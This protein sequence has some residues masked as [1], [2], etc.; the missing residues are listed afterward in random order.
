MQTHTKYLLASTVL[1]S[2]LIFC[3]GNVAAQDTTSSSSAVLEEIQV[4][5][6]RVSES[7]QT[8]PVSVT[9]IGASMLEDGDFT[10]LGDIQKM[11]PNLTLHVGDASNAV[12]YIR[13]VGQVDSLAFAD[14]GVG[15]YMDDVYLGRAQGA[16]LDVL[17][18]ERI[19][20]LRGPQGTLYGRNTIG[21]AVK[22]V[23]KKPGDTL[24][25]DA[26]ITVGSYD[27]L[28]VKAS[29]GGPIV[30]DKL[31]GKIS[32]AY[33][34]RDGFATNE[35]NGKDDSDK[36][37]WA[38]KAGLYF[39]PTED[40]SIDFTL[41][42]SESH[43][44]TSRTPARMTSVFG[45]AEPNDDP[46]VI[47][48]DFNDLNKLDVYGGAAT[49]AYDATDSLTL[50]SITS[51]REMTYDTHLDL[52]AT[53]FAFFGI[54]VH[55]E[56]NQFSQ[57]LQLSYTS[58]ALDVIG[59][60]YYFKEHDNT[61]AG[62]FGPVIAFVSGSVN[63]QH[64]KS[65]AGYLNT[66]Y[67]MND[68]LSLTAGIRYTKE[69]KDFDRIQ[70]FFSADTLLPVPI[71]QG[72]RVTDLTVD[73]TWSS[74]SPKVGFDYQINDDLMAYVSASRGFKSG[75]F[76][77][78]SNSADEAIPFDPETMWSYETGL[79]STL[80]D[81]RM[82]LNIAGFMNKYKDLQLSSFVANPDGSFRAL[83]T[84]AGRATTKGI[85]ME[86]LARVSEGLTLQGSLGYMDAEYDEYIGPDGSDI[87]D[88][89]HMV[90]SPK[91]TARLGFNYEHQLQS[92]G[93]IR[94]MGDVNYRSKTYSTV[95][96]SEILAQDGY[97]L[98]SA[99]IAYVAE[100]GAWEVALDGKNLT[101][102]KYLSHG[103]DLSDSLGYQLGYY[104]NPRT[105][106]LS[107][108]TRF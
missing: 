6:R 41:D 13:G 19:E 71:G 91:W 38:L 51:Y 45:A 101:N 84:N 3:A 50:K 28:D 73:D 103:F 7:L 53:E 87:S 42:G 55:E 86:M 54:Y 66:N 44:D 12:V 2:G 94:L 60:L 8:V 26:S 35:A 85:E 67:R 49:I 108:K 93:N 18:A 100:G 57:E 36:E 95:S 39:T 77:G 83:F 58:D 62:V 80:L 107:L 33:L 32:A 63:D 20:V 68:R 81:G 46:F 104:G 47:A 82:T 69:K 1:T 92:G 78:R 21:G 14:P 10:D 34:S 23:S 96:S 56:Q 25:G 98:V 24:A 88:M 76:D 4:S 61:F 37:T 40:L 89:R 11:V 16:F 52:D 64:N 97:A 75:G 99:G 30:E 106:G 29:V 79:K 105:W 43:P 70:E 22:F 27:R 31:A 15:I 17:D 74:W 102:K 72:A 48:A 5:A 65:Y 90:N 59:G 9:A